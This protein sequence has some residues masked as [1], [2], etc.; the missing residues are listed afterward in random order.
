[1]PIGDVAVGGRSML[2]LLAEGDFLLVCWGAQPRAG[3]V[4]VGVLRDRPGLQVVKRAAAPVDGGWLLASD[5]AGAPGAVGGVG[6]VQAVVVGR[7][8][9]L[10]RAGRVRR[11]PRRPWRAGAPL[12][13]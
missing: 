8:W 11:G 13:R 2:P 3:D 1:M 12:R 6:D 4:V 9:P 10:G 5:N 7:Y